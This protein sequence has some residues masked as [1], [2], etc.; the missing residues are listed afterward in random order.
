M[1]MYSSATLL[2]TCHASAQPS[3]P[4]RARGAS[5][6]RGAVLATLAPFFLPMPWRQAIP[7]VATGD[8]CRGDRR[9]LPWRQ[10]I[11]A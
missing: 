3:T 9:S 6:A 1:Y 11:P 7:A 4:C 2:S 10:E 5:T 8:P